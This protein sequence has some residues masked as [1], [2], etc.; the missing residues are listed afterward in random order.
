MATMETYKSWG[1][2][3]GLVLICIFLV[4]KI[5]VASN[6]ITDLTKQVKDL[7]TQ[8][9]TLDT[10]ATGQKDANMMTRYMVADAWLSAQSPEA[11][12]GFAEFMSDP[13]YQCPK[14]EV[15]V[16]VVREWYNLTD[17]EFFHN[18]VLEYKT[19]YEVFFPDGTIKCYPLVI[20]GMNP[21]NVSCSNLCP[22]KAEQDRLWQ[23]QTK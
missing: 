18:L 19:G 16:T 12:I 21:K 2:S 22:S 17:N 11:K 5:D 10:Q 15:D 7:Q 14:E 20:Q 23:N 4:Y 1:I 9:Q 3:I 8:A 13:T 6:H